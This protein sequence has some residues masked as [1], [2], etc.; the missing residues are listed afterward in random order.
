[1]KRLNKTIGK[2]RSKCPTN[3]T[4]P[5]QFVNPMK[6]L[7]Q[8]AFFPLI[9]RIKKMPPAKRRWNYDTASWDFLRPP[10]MGPNMPPGKVMEMTTPPG[11]SMGMKPSPEEMKKM[12]MMQMKMMP[13]EK[14][15][16]LYNYSL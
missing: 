12:Q 3:E 8:A 13:G 7:L 9:S 4:N 6:V 5:S 11:N 10:P 14:V 2:K 16:K 15:Q 1:M